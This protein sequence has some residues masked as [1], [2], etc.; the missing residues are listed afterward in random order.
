MDDHNSRDN[1]L[2]FKQEL[3]AR[4]VLKADDS[5]GGLPAQT[6]KGGLGAVVKYIFKINLANGTRAGGNKKK[7]RRSEEAM[8]PANGHVEL[9]IPQRPVGWVYKAVKRDISH[10]LKGRRGE[11]G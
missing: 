4:G 2:R 7:G 5:G 10:F 3:E 1:V 11:R 9:F 6:A 8:L